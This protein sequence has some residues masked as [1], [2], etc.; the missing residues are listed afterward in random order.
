M[1]KSEWCFCI[2]CTLA[3][4]L[5]FIPIDTAEAATLDLNG[6]IIDMEQSDGDIVL[7]NGITMISENFLR[8]DLYLNVGKN[9]KQFSLKNNHDDF[10]IEG[11]VGEN[12]LS[13]NEK[14]IALPVSVSERD[15]I[16]YVP[17]R[18]LLELFGTVEWN[19]D[20]QNI[21]VR[22]DYNDQMT[23]S[24]VE[25]VE[26]PLIYKIASDTGKPYDYSNRAIRMTPEGMIV[27]E[28]G[29]AGV[30]N[31]V[32]VGDQ[33]VIHP[34]HDNYVIRGSSY[35]VEEDYLYWIE[36]PDPNIEIEKEQKWY[37]YL[38]ER[39]KGAAPICIDQES[40]TGLQ[41]ISAFA[42]FYL[43]ICDFKNGNMIWFAADI[44]NDK[45]CI[46]L[47]QHDRQETVEL[48]QFPLEK[49]AMF[50]TQVVIGEK[51]AF[52]T[53]NILTDGS[54]R[55]GTMNRVHLDSGKIELFSNGY[56]VLTPMIAGNY[57]VVRAIP[58]GGN[59][60]IDEKTLR[61]TS[62]ELWIYDL[63]KNEWKFKVTKDMPMLHEDAIL[64]DSV[65]ISDTQLV[66]KTDVYAT[67][68]PMVVIN[69]EKGIAQIVSDEAGN[70][71]SFNP[72]EE[73]IF[74][75]GSDESNLVVLSTLNADGK[76][77]RMYEIYF[78]K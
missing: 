75:R 9:G 50:G 33:I 12:T 34:Q 39:K 71:F 38:Q 20:E 46:Y 64:Q 10:C 53:I 63:T 76:E 61:Y 26:T 3:S 59:Y 13:F 1:K 43:D 36:Y 48:E 47:Y 7:E 65:I 74:F 18:P 31:A 67:D 69:L 66:L 41:K 52:W 58:E 24:E 8:D 54:W 6:S 77:Q 21:T 70:I 19:G 73:E 78:E 45:G 49:L 30:L 14:S 62:G 15:G 23:L 4:V 22:Y 42:D 5:L 25:V 37:L 44:E 35:A 17:L 11:S 55:Y 72:F 68:A 32:K 51:D 2:L 29:E 57:L 40:F 60:R 16:L 27:E 56:N 28:R